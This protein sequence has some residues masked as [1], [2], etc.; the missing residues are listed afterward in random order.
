MT[1]HSPL[2]WV[3]E[4]EYIRSH[5]GEIVADTYTMPTAE[6]GETMEANAAF[7]IKAVN[8]HDAL[9]SAIREAESVIDGYVGDLLTGDQMH[10][11]GCY[12]LLKIIRRI[13]DNL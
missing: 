12:E 6:A 8:N 7:I 10:Q 5:T 11:T 2:P 13:T 4:D 1:E 3:F 9:V